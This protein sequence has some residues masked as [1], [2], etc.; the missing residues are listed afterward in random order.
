MWSERPLRSL[1]VFTP[2]DVRGAVGHVMVMPTWQMKHDSPNGMYP[3]MI[4]R[5][6]SRM[7]WTTPMAEPPTASPAHCS[8][9]TRIVIEVI[10]AG[11]CGEHASV[12]CGV[13]MCFGLS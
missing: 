13:G 7:S 1:I 6:G 8:K 4:W 10:T 5:R 11:C 3:S 2:Q 12:E 9:V